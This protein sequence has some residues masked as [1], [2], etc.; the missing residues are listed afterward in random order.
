MTAP[1][2][3]SLMANAL[4][5][6]PRGPVSYATRI[7][8]GSRFATCKTAFAHPRESPSAPRIGLLALCWG[9]SRSAGH[10]PA[11][12]ARAPAATAAPRQAAPRPRAG[13]PQREP[14]RGAVIRSAAC[15]R[16]PQCFAW[17]RHNSGGEGAY[18]R[19]R[20]DHATAS[21]S[22]RDREVGLPMQRCRLPANPRQRGQSPAASR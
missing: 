1:L 22:R 2:Q 19:R 15:M 9:G 8:A 3:C 18:Q 21:T 16:L 13:R 5:S 11:V 17:M 10:C 6:F 12:P 7:A 14:A 4:L 20:Y